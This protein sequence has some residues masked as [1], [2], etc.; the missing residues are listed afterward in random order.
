MPYSIVNFNEVKLHKDLRLD[1]EHYHP[2]HLESLRKIENKS[3]ILSKFIIH[4]SG[5]ATPLGAEYPEE[6]ILF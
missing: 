4:I 1:A 3:Q 6:G 2:H 5:G